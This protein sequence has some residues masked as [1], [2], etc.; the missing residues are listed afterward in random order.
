MKTAEGK[1]YGVEKIKTGKRKDGQ[2]VCFI[3]N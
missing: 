1:E 3:L 2:K